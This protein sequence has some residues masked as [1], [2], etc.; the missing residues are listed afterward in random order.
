[1]WTP[2]V[3]ATSWLGERL[4]A[5]SLQGAVVVALAWA[6]CRWIPRV[7]ASLQ[8]WVWWLVALKLTLTFAA[9]AGSPAAP[10]A[11][12]RIRRDSEAPSQRPTTP[13]RRPPS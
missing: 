5:G 9:S 4:L 6:A 12:C 8:A 11:G 10:A 1:M 3:G 2:L 7:P 13:M